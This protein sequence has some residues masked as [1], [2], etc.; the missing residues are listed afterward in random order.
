MGNCIGSACALP[1]RN[2]KVRP[3]EDEQLLKDSQ[4]SG[5]FETA[6]LCGETL[7]QSS[8]LKSGEMQPESFQRMKIVVNKKQLQLLISSL[9]ELKSTHIVIRSIG[10]RCRK[11]RP[12][13]ATIPEL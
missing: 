7:P 4:S 9:E 3:V 11:W 13:L 10:K 2:K 5:G 12:S 6:T 8:L 1:S